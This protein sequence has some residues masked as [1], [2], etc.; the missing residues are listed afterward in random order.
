MLKQIAV[1]GD[2]QTVRECQAACKRDDIHLIGVDAAQELP[3]TTDAL[4]TP[5]DAAKALPLAL[6]LADRQENILLLLAEAID[7]REQF[8][9]G[10][11]LRVVDHVARFA[12]ALDLTN[13][14][15]I[16]LERGALLRDIG[17][18]K[19]A[20]DVLLNEGVFNYDEWKTIYGHPQ[21]GADLVKECD[22]LKDTEDII[23]FHHECF[24]GTG[25][26]NALEGNEIP[27]HARIV[28]IVDVYCAMSSPRIYRDTVATKEQAIE[29]FSAERGKHFDP[30]LVEV[31]IKNDIGGEAVTAS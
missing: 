15:R 22:G 8:K 10:S 23:R 17:K 24:D 18:L 7:C 6:E 28:K 16:V 21:I 2:G 5:G 20:N 1:I 29:Y 12:I 14:E 11:S 31:F 26:P 27:L 9:P 19:I 4:L 25:Y 13:E 30:E 3:Q